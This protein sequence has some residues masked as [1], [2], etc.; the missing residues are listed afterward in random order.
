MD[1]EAIELLLK[2]NISDCLVEMSV[3]GNK[4][5]LV[6]ISRDFAGLNRVKRQQKVYRLLDTRI[7]SG[8]IHAV[9]MKLMTP[10]ETAHSPD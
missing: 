7:K 1:P 10:D 3:E 6:L 4:L 5:D 9:S 2:D 8:E